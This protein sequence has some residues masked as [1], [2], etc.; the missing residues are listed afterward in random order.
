MKYISHYIKFSVLIPENGSAFLPNIPR[1][2]DIFF[3]KILKHFSFFLPVRANCNWRWVWITGRMVLALGNWNTFSEK[4]VS[5]PFCPL[6]TSYEITWDGTQ[7]S[8]MRDQRLTEENKP[9]LYIKMR[10]YF[11]YKTAARFI[12]HTI[13]TLHNAKTRLH[14]PYG[15]LIMVHCED[16]NQT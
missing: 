12:P 8:A 13:H 9:K 4:L 11:I 7:D 3:F 16:P 1:N 6:K 15:E 2:V 10:N 5:V 14:V